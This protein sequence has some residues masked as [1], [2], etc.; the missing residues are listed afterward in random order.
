MNLRYFRE[1]HKFTQQELASK[2]CMLYQQYQRYESQQRPLPLSV[3]IQLAD[4]YGITL[5][6]LVGRTPPSEQ[7]KG[8]GA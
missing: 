1:L 5:D 7:K 3:A 8:E 2:L 4:L 6:E